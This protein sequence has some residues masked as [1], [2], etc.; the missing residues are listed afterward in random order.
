ML[1]ANISESPTRNAKIFLPP[2]KR[3]LHDG[4]GAVVGLEQ[5][6]IDVERDGPARTSVVLACISARTS[7]SLDHLVGAGEQRRRY[8]EAE[9]LRRD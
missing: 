8:V 4:G 2:T 9:R 7:V 6:A 3:L 5:M 1:T